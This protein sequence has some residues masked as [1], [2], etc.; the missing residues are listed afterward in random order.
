MPPLMAA[1][2]VSLR[3][4][5]DLAIGTPEVGAVNFT[6]LH[7]LI[8]AILKNLHL[9]DTVVD[10][11]SLSPEQSYLFEAPRPSLS[12]VQEAVSKEKRKSPVVR[13]P[14]ETLESGAARAP[15][16]KLES[17]AA[18][19]PAPKLESGLARAPSLT[20]ESQVQ[21]LGGQ[22]HDLGLQVK[23]MESQVQGILTHVQHVTDLASRLDIDAPEWLEEQEIAMPMPE[24]A[25]PMPDMAKL[26][27]ENAISK[28]DKA[29]PDKERMG[30]M[31]IRKDRPRVSRRGPSRWLSSCCWS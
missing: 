26:M 19:A 10:I 21:D 7:T 16:P 18:R 15:A 31:R 13:T 12:A 25:M 1:T 3:Q 22:V 11:Q 4:L 30:L 27:P 6:A 29:T 2:K 8:V 28:P 20:L 14:S 5:A 17:G 9:Q 24:M 23:T